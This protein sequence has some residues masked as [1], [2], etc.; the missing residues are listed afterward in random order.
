M[1]TII[2]G[3]NGFVGH[4]FEIKDSI[5]LSKKECDLLDYNSTYA[6]FKTYKNKEINII[7]LSAK[8]AGFIYNKDHNVEMLYENTLMSLNLIKTLKELNI[9]TYMIY[10]ASVCCYDKSFKENN[11]FNGKPHKL[12]FGYGFGKK[13]GI[14]ALEALEIDKPDLIKY[15]VL[16]PTNMYGEYD[17]FNSETCHIIPNMIRQ[18]KANQNEIVVLGNCL[19][20]RDFLYVR[21]LGNII[22]LCYKNK[23]T[24]IYNVSSN[25]TTSVKNIVLKLKNI[26]KYK[27]NIIFSTKDKR[28][29]RN[30]SNLNLLKKIKYKFTDL[31]I[32]LKNT[33]IYY[34]NITK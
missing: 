6:Y 23:I 30:I 24:G 12:N 10:I 14:Y 4:S 29:N 9:K 5:C 20:K 1:K 32:G 2:L 11:I 3:K 15:C 19:N 13:N 34:N 27:G 16:V 21:D 17:D 28:N 8:V 31:N 7:N 26:I 22:K 33:V 25:K 18:M